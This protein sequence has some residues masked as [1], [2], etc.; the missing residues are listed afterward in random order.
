[1]LVADWPCL[2]K[3]YSQILAN[4]KRLSQPYSTSLDSYY[5]VGLTVDMKNGEIPQ[6]A[7]TI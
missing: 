4:A 1:M 7:L 3:L 2:H 5:D 6:V